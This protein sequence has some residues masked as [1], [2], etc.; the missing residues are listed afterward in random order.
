M[1][2]IEDWCL[3]GGAGSYI[4]PEKIAFRLEGIVYGHP[5][6]ENGKRITTSNIITAEWKN[7]IVFT[8]SGHI[9]ELGTP[10]PEWIEW[11]KE[12]GYEKS[13][14]WLDL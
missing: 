1:I 13:L 14:Q 2:R 8:R 10:N 3:R 12:K 4:S 7:R 6:K 9:Y 11:L 5:F